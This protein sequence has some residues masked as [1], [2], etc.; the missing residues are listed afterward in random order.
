MRA[1][2]P[3]LPSAP[4]FPKVAATWGVLLGH[5][6]EKHDC[7]AL[8]AV[9]AQ[10]GALATPLQPRPFSCPLVTVNHVGCQETCS[11]VL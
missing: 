5:Y 1:S 6:V 4:M 10:V 8:S 2:P 9:A 7:D 11:D 3:P